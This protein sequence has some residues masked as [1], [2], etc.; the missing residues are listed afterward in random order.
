ML[1]SELTRHLAEPAS[2]GG[3][4]RQLDDRRGHGCGVAGRRHDAAV[5]RRG[6]QL[7]AFGLGDERSAAG[8]NPGQL[9]T[10]NYRLFPRG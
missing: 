9:E 8:E 3:V 4:R 1:D 6:G 10:S 2:A 7:A 5:A